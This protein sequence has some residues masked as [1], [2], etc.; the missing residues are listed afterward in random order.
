[1]SINLSTTFDAEAIRDTSSH[2]GS[3]VYNGSFII[4][5]IIIEN[6]LDEDVTL[7]C[8]ASMHADFA[9][10]FDVGAPFD[11]AATTVDYQSCDTY[12][13]YWR[14][15]ATCGTAPTTGVLTIHVMG[16]SS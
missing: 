15:E 14:I 5:T 1:M 4:K 2:N 7:Q 16:V 13:P 6:G 3:T 11:Q 9:S 12:F 10:S 8:Q